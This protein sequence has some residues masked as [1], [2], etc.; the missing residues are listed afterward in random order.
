MRKGWI[1]FVLGSVRVKISL[2]STYLPSKTSLSL[3][4]TGVAVSS[5]FSFL[6][7]Q[8]S[9]PDLRNLPPLNSTTS[10]Q[11]SPLNRQP[12]LTVSVQK[13]SFGLGASLVAVLPFQPPMKSLSSRSFSLFSFCSSV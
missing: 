9:S 5:Y 3:P 7:F 1:S 10:Q 12:Q 2:S 13:G 11:S 6:P 8:R 4:S